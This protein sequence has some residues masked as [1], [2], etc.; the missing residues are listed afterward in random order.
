MK[1]WSVEF[2]WRILL[3]IL[4]K[5]MHFTWSI[6]RARIAYVIFGLSWSTTELTIW[7]AMIMNRGVH[8]AGRPSPLCLGLGLYVLLLG[9]SSDLLFGPTYIWVWLHFSGKESKPGPGP[10]D[11][12][13]NGKERLRWDLNKWHVTQAQNIKSVEQLHETVWSLS[14]SFS[15]SNVNEG[16]AKAS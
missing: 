1:F 11:F 3:V 7:M 12:K 5:R 2:D 9:L 4:D 8:G 6:W 13:H 14:L 16:W 15:P 10:P